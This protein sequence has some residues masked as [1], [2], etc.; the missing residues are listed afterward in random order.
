MSVKR[1]G[2]GPGSN[3][4]RTLVLRLRE[5]SRIHHRLRQANREAL[6]SKRHQPPSYALDGAGSSAVA[7][8]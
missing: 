8:E 2:Q 5:R 1:A 7:P 6:R 3:H 4:V